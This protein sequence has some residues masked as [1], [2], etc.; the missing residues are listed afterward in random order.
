ML[1]AHELPLF[2]YRPESEFVATPGTVG[3]I[4]RG[5]G[6]VVP[7]GDVVIERG[8]EAFNRLYTGFL[9]PVMLN[10]SIRKLTE[11]RSTGLR[12]K[13]LSDAVRNVNAGIS[14]LHGRGTSTPTQ[15][16]R[17][18]VYAPRYLRASLEVSLKA[19][20]G[21]VKLGSAPADAAMARDTILRWLA[22]AVVTTTVANAMRGHDTE[23]DP[24]KPNWLTLR[25]VNGVDLRILGNF[26]TPARLV[27]EVGWGSPY[28]DGNWVEN[29]VGSLGRT[30][31]A[32]SNPVL[33]PL[34]EGVIT[35]ETFLGKQLDP[36][37]RPA[38]FV[39]E[40]ALDLMPFTAQ[41]LFREGGLAAGF[42]A[43]GA[44]AS[45]VTPAERRNAAQDEAAREITGEEA[46][47]ALDRIKGTFTGAL[48]D[49]E[50][51]FERLPGAQKAAIRQDPEI[52]RL[53][54]D[55]RERQKERGGDSAAIA[56]IGENFATRRDAID[57]WLNS[58]RDSGGN[59]F[60]GDDY[61][62]VMHELQ[63]DR[64]AAY[65]AI[66]LTGGDDALRGWYDL[67]D[68]AVDEAGRTDYD[69]LDVLQAEYEAQHTDIR[70]KLERVTGAK[71]SP[72]Q[73][74]LRQAR[75]Q[76]RRYYD[77]PR[78]L[79]VDSETA[80]KAQA[81]D[82]L[83]RELVK[84]GQA[85]N[86]EHAMLLVAGAYGFDY[87]TALQTTRGR[88]PNPEREWFRHSNPLFARFYSD[89]PLPLVA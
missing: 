78:W 44:Q 4:A 28:R 37:A 39:S 36:L 62:K 21:V 79:G 53:E 42:S 40:Q 26:A 5:V 47:S 80:R 77:I 89:I 38:E 9:Q 57:G 64:G 66:G 6:K 23:L 32:K 31:W 3:G 76:A 29:A 63:R 86:R 58:G 2:S 50:G 56:E 24:R 48:K 72:T 81:A 43:T 59:P 73:Q 52:R 34:I 35:G 11:L 51:P 54:R 7:K 75:S 60:T 16:E 82:Q 27:A 61:R 8:F 46:P 71:D 19:L 49:E 67:Y 22:F 65:D 87:V 25:D 84:F 68:E 15:F 85:F 10:E 18:L 55:A 83:A 74:Q 14:R 13:E 45:P 88:P 17:R 30:A 12:G 1:T 41:S 20:E 69:K 33:S 70:A